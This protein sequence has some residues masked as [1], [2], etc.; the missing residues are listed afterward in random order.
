MAA[1]TASRTLGEPDDDKSSRSDR[2]RRFGDRGSV[3]GSPAT[4]VMRVECEADRR[5]LAMVDNS[6]HVRDLTEAANRANVSF[7][8]L[9][10]PE[11][12]VPVEGAS[13]A[14]PQTEHHA[15]AVLDSPASAR[16]RHRRP[17]GAEADGVWTRRCR[18][19]RRR[20]VVLPAD[21]PFIQREARWALPRPQRA[22]DA[23]RCEGADA[24]RL[25]RA[26]DR[27]AAE[28]PPPARPADGAVA[29]FRSLRPDCA[30]PVPDPHL[31]VERGR[32]RHV[33]DRGGVGLPHAPGA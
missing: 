30:P 24:A 8:P 29:Q 3:Q 15:R 20:V 26:H 12:T 25:P 28:R 6:Q 23:S 22:R 31:V 10:A 4:P 32:G 7:Y 9:Y 27:R 14:V 16:R 13:R 33:L 11:V 21:L 18:G 19:S 5:R 1:L 17:G 2:L